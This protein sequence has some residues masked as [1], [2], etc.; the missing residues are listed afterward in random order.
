[1]SALP[2]APEAASAPTPTSLTWAA[3]AFFV[4]NLGFGVVLPWSPG[5]VGASDPADALALSALAYGLG[6]LL[7]QAPA[8]AW[9]DR[10]GAARFLRPALLTYAASLGLLA[11]GDP[12]AFLVGRGLEGIATGVAQ[13]AILSVVAEGGAG[14]LGERI[15]KVA[16]IGTGGVLAGPALALA[17]GQGGPLVPV[18]IAAGCA[19]LVAL[20]APRRR[21]GRVPEPTR[22]ERSSLLR[23]PA[24]VALVLPVAFGK[25]SFTALEGILPLH[26]PRCCGL[27]P[28]GVAGWMLLLGVAFGLAQPLGGWLSDRCSAR[29]VAAPGFLVGLGGLA[30]LAGTSSGMRET[31]TALLGYGLGQSLVFAATLRQL[32]ATPFPV[33]RGTV[34]GVHGSLTDVATIVGPTVFVA[35]Y[36][37]HA[38][39]AFAGLAVSGAIC[40]AGYFWLSR[41][42]PRR[43]PPATA[44]DR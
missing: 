4:L 21:G 36:G 34:L 35:L 19:L 2:A 39:L 40:A 20:A 27:L 38:S 43:E 33:G 5:L 30:W 22:A 26:G 1:M 28:E 23:T 15:G 10:H 17:A 7:V 13:V 24:F 3:L 25:L 14:D 42:P 18:M 8:G 31:T 6:K 9:V 37:R 32:L 41:R 29:A 16:G 11:L 44:G 12:L